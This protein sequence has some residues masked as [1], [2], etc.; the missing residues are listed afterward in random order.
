MLNRFIQQLSRYLG[1][2][3]LMVALLGSGFAMAQAEPTMKEIY[4]A[5]Q[6]GKLDQAQVMVQQVLVIHPN[7]AKAHYVQAELYARQGQAGKGRDALAMAEKIAPG[8]PFAKPEAVQAL[9]TQLAAK[10]G[11][12]TAGSLAT[13]AAKEARP[14]LGGGESSSSSSSSFPLGL[15]LALGG[16]AI[17]LA[18]FF[19]RK[20]PAPV[21]AAP[22]AY[23]NPNTTSAMGN[24]LSGPQTFGT[25]GGGAATYGGQ[26]GYGQAGYG[27]PNYGGQQPAGSGLG[28][29]LAGGLAT[30][31]AVGAGVM[32]AQAI[33]KSFMDDG[34]NKDHAAAADGAGSG[35]GHSGD[36]GAS[37]F[38][39][40]P[41]SG[42]DNMG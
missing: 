12:S 27:Q 22:F 32:A 5:A 8:L 3:L 14:V 40:A 4:Q 16:G 36:A 41:L 28:G 34:S 7:S 13:P 11:A 42:N 39:S 30:G 21:A 18:I 23:G 25:A 37:S 1:L 29:R 2:G 31:L 19:M 10:P 17:A 9:R 6:A 24:G 20:K 38:S 35:T 33:G 15:G 26:P